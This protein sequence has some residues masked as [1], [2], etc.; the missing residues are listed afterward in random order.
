MVSEK[1][2][3]HT[4][5]L[6]KTCEIYNQALTYILKVMFQEFSLTYDESMKTTTN[7]VEKLIHHTAKNPQPK[8][9]DFNALFPKYPSYFR[10]ATIASAME[11]GLLGVRITL[12]GK[13][14][15]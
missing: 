4:T 13:K 7:V 3:S 15:D 5:S 1:I 8:Y 11:N 6:D 14:N 2:V 9:E 12:I 10:R